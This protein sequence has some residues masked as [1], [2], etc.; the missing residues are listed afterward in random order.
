MELI[1]RQGDVLIF[2]LEDDEAMPS[3]LQTVQPEHG[4]LIVRRGEATGHHH[5]VAAADAEALQATADAAEVYLRVHR[6]T[7]M[8]HQQHGPVTL[9]LGA[10]LTRP[11]RT[12]S[13]E[14]I[15][16]VAD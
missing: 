15:R 3:S 6:T 11:K 4:R 16:Y 10:Y 12:Y 1:A 13:P 8:D 14:E 9:P 2:R 5:S 7:T